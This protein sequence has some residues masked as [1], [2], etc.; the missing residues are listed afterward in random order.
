MI[1][2]IHTV[3]DNKARIYSTPF[4][5]ARPEVA[6]RD[7]KRAVNDPTSDIFSS[8]GD[9]DLLAL[10]TYD[11]ETAIITLHPAPEFIQ[12]AAFLKQFTGE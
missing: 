12:N 1:K 10:G 3:Y 6:L 9:F 11:D 2:Y 7:F 4:F 5:A 8:A